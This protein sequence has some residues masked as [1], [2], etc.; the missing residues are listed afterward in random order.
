MADGQ[1]LQAALFEAMGEA[2]RAL[3]QMVPLG[4]ALAEAEREY[5]V[6]KRTRTLWERSGGAPVTIIGALRLTRDCAQAEYDANREAL[7]L[8]KKRIDTIREMIAR[9]WSANGNDQTW[10]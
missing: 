3:C 6:Q 8:A 1:N 4:V 10:N 5:R 2:Q 9:E 7:L